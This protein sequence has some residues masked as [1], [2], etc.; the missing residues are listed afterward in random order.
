MIEP[1]ARVVSFEDA[2]FGD[3]LDQF[4]KDNQESAT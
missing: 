4:E 2:D 1:R 3:M